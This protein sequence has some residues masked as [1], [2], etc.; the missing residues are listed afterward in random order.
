MDLLS[1]IYL[2]HGLPDKAAVLLAAR[3]ALVPDDSRVL[4]SLALAQLRSGKPERAM[5]TLERIALLGEVD[6][7]FHL[8]RAQIFMALG[9][10]SDAVNAM[11]VHVALRTEKANE[12]TPQ[13]KPVVLTK[14]N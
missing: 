9:Q 2:R 13:A 1:Y 10:I 5:S 14:V 8:V 11:R 4:L 7:A 6:A 3:D 12:R